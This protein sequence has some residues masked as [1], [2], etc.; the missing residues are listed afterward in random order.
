MQIFFFF[1]WGE[2][3]KYVPDYLICTDTE[4][5]SRLLCLFYVSRLMGYLFCTR[6]AS[7]KHSAC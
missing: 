5:I 6:W 1:K 2:P 7:S 3:L 4:M